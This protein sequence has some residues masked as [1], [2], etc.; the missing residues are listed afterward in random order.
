MGTSIFTFLDNNKVRSNDLCQVCYDPDGKYSPDEYG[1]NL[2]EVISILKQGKI[3]F[4]LKILCDKYRGYL[5]IWYK[6]WMWLNCPRLTW[7]SSPNIGENN[8]GWC[9]WLHTYEC[10]CGASSS[11]EDR[12]LVIE[13]LQQYN[14]KLVDIADDPEFNTND[15]AVV[16]QPFLTNTHIPRLSSGDPGYKVAW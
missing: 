7:V 9:D 11:E 10:P 2:R 13:T 14:E 1:K 12:T 8:P 4:F 3:S 6:E 16:V 5:W 15:F